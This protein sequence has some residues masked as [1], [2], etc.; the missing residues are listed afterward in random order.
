MSVM[1]PRDLDRE[2]Y[3]MD[4]A[5]RAAGFPHDGGLSRLSDLRAWPEGVRQGMDWDD[6]ARAELADGRSYLLWGMLPFYEGYLQGE[7]DAT[8]Q[9]ERRL[10][11]LSHLISAWMALHDVR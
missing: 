7:P 6:E 2:A 11:A 3:F 1:V 8:I 9:V 4:L 10:R 5:A